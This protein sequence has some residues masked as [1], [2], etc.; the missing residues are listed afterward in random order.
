MRDGLSVAIV[1]RPNVGKS[2]LMNRLLCQERAI[3]TPFPGTTRDAI[4]GCIQLDGLPVTLWD[5]AGLR[6]TDEPV[7]AIGVRK[8]LERA[9]G[10]DMLIF[11]MEAN[12]AFTEGDHDI[13]MI[14]RPCRLSSFSTKSIW[15]Q[16]QLRPSRRRVGRMQPVIAISAL[17]GRGLS[18]LKAAI[19]RSARWDSPPGASQ[20]V[21]NLRQKQL[22]ESCLQSV[23]AAA[24]CIA[25]GGTAELVTV[26]LKDG[27]SQL[28]AV[29]GVGVS[30]DVIEDIFGRFCIGK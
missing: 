15:S 30:T 8:A 17:S 18:E 9:A 29:L 12:R 5:T 7:E 21:V 3:V 28:D 23:N 1:G 19:R 22:L 2:S 4:E 14:S 16:T 6:Q 20:L 11:V 13:Q 27:L 26:H 10:S 25:N 24:D